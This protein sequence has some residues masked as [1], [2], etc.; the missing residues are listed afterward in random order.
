MKYYLYQY[1]ANWADEMDVAG[2]MA[3]TE[4]EKDMALA[5]IKKDFRRGGTIYIG[6]NEDIEYSDLDEVMNDVTITEISK[7]EYDVL[8][9]LFGGSFGENGPCDNF[10]FDDDRY[11][12]TFEEDEMDEETEYE[13]SADKVVSFIK[14]EFNLE[15][16]DSRSDCYSSFLWKPTPK[17]Q[18]EITIPYENEDEGG[19]EIEVALKL[20][21]RELDIEFF[22]VEITSDSNYRLVDFIKKCV[23]KASKF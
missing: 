12:E 9:K 3:L 13:E 5:K 11:D 19:G 4:T 18:I 17:T 2:F 15:E 16:N 23:Q 1:D 21:G 7:Q 20:N 8:I 14:K 6:S 22:D 10:D